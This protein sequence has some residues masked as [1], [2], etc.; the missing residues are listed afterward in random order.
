MW[1]GFGVEDDDQDGLL[2]LVAEPHLEGERA[3]LLDRRDQ[4]FVLTDRH[5]DWLGVLGGNT[6]RRTSRRLGW[7][8]AVVAARASAKATTQRRTCSGMGIQPFLAGP[9]LAPT[10]FERGSEVEG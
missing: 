4:G 10:F 7:A 5:R 2:L 9:T 6:S 8:A 3:E 1:L